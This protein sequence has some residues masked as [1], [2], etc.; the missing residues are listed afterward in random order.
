MRIFLCSLIR[1]QPTLILLILLV[2]NPVF[3]QE[4]TH[5]HDEIVCAEKAQFEGRNLIKKRSGEIVFHG[6]DIIY[7]RCEWKLNPKSNS[8]IEGHILFKF[9]ADNDLDSLAF[10]LVNELKIDSITRN[11]QFL[12]YERKANRVLVWK[13]ASKSSVKW[14]QNSIDSFT[15]HY[16]GN[17][18]SVSG[19]FG[20]YV[21][22]NHQT[23]PIIHTLSQPYGAPFWW[24]CKQSLNDKIDSIDIVV[25]TASDFKVGSN[26]V[27]L[28]TT[29]TIQGWHKIHWKHRYPVATYLV[30]IAVTNYAEFTDYAKFWNRTDSLPVV[31]YVF[32]QFL[33]SSK[34][35]AQITLPMLRLMDSLFIPYPYPQEKYGHAQFTWGGGMEH[36]TMS[37]MGN[38]SR[39]LIA[40]ELAHQWFGDMVTCGSW[41][42][43]WLNEGFATYLTE[44]CYQYLENDD[45][46]KKKMRAMRANIT[47]DPNGSVKPADTTQVNILFNGRLTYRKGAWLLHMLR[48]KIGDSLFFEGCRKHLS[49][50][51]AYGFSTTAAFQGIMESVSGQ[52]LDTFFKQ[53]YEGQGHPDLKIN[54]KQRGRKLELSVEQTPSNSMMGFWKIPVPVE[55]LSKPNFSGIR[56]S[57]YLVFYPDS[58]S[59]NYTLDIDF[60]VDTV[61]FDP[62]VSVLAKASVGGMNLDAQQK[63]EIILAPNPGTDVL[64][65][66][67]RNPVLKKVE[68]YNSIGQIVYRESRDS[69]QTWVINVTQWPVGPYFTRIYTDN[70]VYLDKWLRI[71]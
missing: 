7:H 43:L 28:S 45:S 39:D 52:N 71:D 6:Y 70:F 69:T 34:T 47:A 51:Q 59:K 13:T 41:N 26:G 22:D 55:F 61:V 48:H 10:D 18:A 65:I 25:E 21:Y 12:F 60:A 11:G 32:P 37:F 42:D 2:I 57:K 33:N 36:Q 19:G 23:G 8:N 9:K 40:H 46:F 20:S 31:N 5:I 49:G 62:K 16:R 3:A 4:E 35:E 56:T 38:F 44:V 30:A 66:F 54:W 50:S 24:P 67:A 53:W 58:L 63:E 68:V 17:P 64:Q 14:N 1:K 15:V 29:P 27:L